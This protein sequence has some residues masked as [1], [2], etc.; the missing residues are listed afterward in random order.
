MN[1]SVRETDMGIAWVTS[2]S[3][4]QNTLKLEWFHEN[5]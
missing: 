1:R 3:A 5:G 4:P 2:G